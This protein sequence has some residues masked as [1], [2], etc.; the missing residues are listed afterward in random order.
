[1]VFLYSI[2]RLPSMTGR[3]LGVTQ[4]TRVVFS[5]RR[6]RLGGY[7]WRCQRPD[8]V[9]RHRLSRECVCLSM[10]EDGEGIGGSDE[11]NG[12]EFYEA[13][14]GFSEETSMGINVEP[15]MFQESEF[16]LILAACCVGISTGIGVVIFNDAVA[17]I[18]H[19][20]WGN[21]TILD[22]RQILSRI[23]SGDL[24]P[25]LFLPPIIASFI[26]GL[27]SSQTERRDVPKAAPKMFLGRIS[28]AVIGL[29]SGVSLGPEGPSVEIGRGVSQIFVNIMK[30][31]KK[32]ISS[33]VAAGSGAGV[34]AGFNAPIAGV[35][36]AVETVLQ[37]EGT[38]P[39]KVMISQEKESSGLTIAMILLASVL[40]AVVSQ[41][42]LGSSPAFRVPDYSLESLYELPLYIIFGGVC[43][44]VSS[45]FLFSLSVATDTFNTVRSTDDST[46][47]LIGLPILG[48]LATG[49]FAL[50]Y[51]EILYE[52]FDNVNSVLSAPRGDYDASILFQ[53]VVLKIIATSI[54]RGSG[55]KGGIYAPSI[56]V[57]AALGSSFGLAC[58]HIGDIVGVDVSPPQAY[59]LVGVGAMLAS[60]CDIPLTSILLLFELTRDYLIILPTLA[61]VGISYWVSTNFLSW[62][63]S[64]GTSSVQDSG[65][66]SSGSFNGTNSLVIDTS[67]PFTIAQICALLESHESGT[68]LIV[69]EQKNS[70]ATVSLL[71]KE[72]P[73]KG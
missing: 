36:F 30:S 17:G 5:S 11:E 16:A 44:I 72:N 8:D 18:R 52:G 58:N 39:S 63:R 55:L 2:E 45:T 32:H 26:V 48:G 57:G 38:I 53:I 29:G 59:A 24:Y 22:G 49:T 47:T 7:T 65:N 21:D 25:R 40:A 27:V 66:G 43:G 13:G 15:I 20:I 35:F 73:V 71:R 14:D 37:R 6:Y 70:I 54:C 12:G 50:L 46:R 9:T 41:A 3:M 56:F 64:Q 68:A 61:A 34:A 51:P 10:P 23:P 69:D 67:S 1:V 19:F 28:S 33:L 42:G 4:R 62:R 31:G 60:A